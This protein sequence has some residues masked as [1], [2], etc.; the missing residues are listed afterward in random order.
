MKIHAKI[1]LSFVVLFTIS[2]TIIAQD[3]HW[4]QWYNAPLYY[5]PATTGAF[6][7]DERVN[8]NYK[9]QWRSISSPYK[10]F[11]AQYDMPFMKKKWKK[12][13]KSG[14]NVMIEI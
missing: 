9:D 12:R 10:T 3:V 13:R 4:S 8:L 2:K 5:N 11:M 6:N 14:K 7:G 1:V